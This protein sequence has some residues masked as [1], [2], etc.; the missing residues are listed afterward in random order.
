VKSGTTTGV[1][2]TTTSSALDPA[3]RAALQQKL[4]EALTE[5]RL[6]S[7]DIYRLVAGVPFSVSKFDQAV[8]IA[9]RGRSG[10]VLQMTREQLAAL[11]VGTFAKV[12]DVLRN[13]AAMVATA[14]D[15]RVAGT[16]DQSIAAARRAMVRMAQLRDAI[17]T[18]GGIAGLGQTGTDVA[19]IAIVVGV[20]LSLTGAGGV[21]GILLIGGGAAYLLAQSNDELDAAEREVGQYLRDFEA[22]CANRPDRPACIQEYQQVVSQATASQSA[23]I[24]ANAE[25]RALVERTRME[26]TLG[27][28]LRPLGEA[29]PYLIAGGGV[30]VLGIALYFTWPLLAGFRRGTKAIVGNRRRNR[31]RR[32]SRKA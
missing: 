1:A 12:E 20:L 5:Y 18:A 17:Q 26:G 24:Q 2:M 8:S 11:I 32:K 9:R 21:V 28:L 4:N 30:V 3:T 23:L 13:S 22:F 31:R 14:R 19:Q 15:R 27:W 16:V 7:T 29:A 6:M 25:A 10:S